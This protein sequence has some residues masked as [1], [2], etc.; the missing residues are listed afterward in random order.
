MRRAGLSVIVWQGCMFVEGQRRA[1]F[2]RKVSKNVSCFWHVKHQ[3]SEAHD[4]FMVEPFRL[5]KSPYHCLSSYL[6]SKFEFQAALSV[7]WSFWFAGSRGFLRE[8]YSHVEQLCMQA[9]VLCWKV[10]DGEIQHACGS[11]C[12]FLLL[13][14]RWR[15][16][17]G[18]QISKENNQL[19]VN[20]GTL[21]VLQ[22][23]RESGVF[24]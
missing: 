17:E 10:Q 6:R 16:A 13:E 22:E 2:R 23:N 11:M 19:L 18:C 15:A 5:Y 12:L 3:P 14:L 21:A 7:S 8:F 24:D 9:W 1:E 20:S 4:S